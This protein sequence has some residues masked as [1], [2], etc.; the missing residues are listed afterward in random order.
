MD[1]RRGNY[2][3]CVH[4]AAGWRYQHPL[5]E[6]LLPSLRTRWGP[7]TTHLSSARFLLALKKIHPRLMED[8]AP[9]Q[10]T[11]LHFGSG[12]DTLST[13]LFLTEHRTVL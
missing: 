8:V 9:L 13:D 11:A 6:V 1:W 10:K 2:V 5:Y 3:S 7:E 12:C 4:F